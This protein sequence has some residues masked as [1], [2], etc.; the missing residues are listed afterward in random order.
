VLGVLQA[1]ETVRQILTVDK[2]KEP[3]DCDDLTERVYRC[4]ATDIVVSDGA[5]SLPAGRWTCRRAAGPPDRRHTATCARASQ[6]LAP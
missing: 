5:V 1:E 3:F 2:F 4:F 6:R